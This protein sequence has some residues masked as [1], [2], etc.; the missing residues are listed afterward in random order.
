MIAKNVSVKHV[1]GQTIITAEIDGKVFRWNSK[2]RKYGEVCP[3]RKLSY[4]NGR[5]NG[6]IELG[7]KFMS[8]TRAEFIRSHGDKLVKLVDSEFLNI[9]RS[10]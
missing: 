5:K 9:L 10:V 8:M 4:R 1:F 3:D 2:T 6:E 7:Q